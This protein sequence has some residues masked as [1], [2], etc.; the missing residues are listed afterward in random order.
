MRRNFRGKTGFVNLGIVIADGKGLDRAVR[1]LLHDR[2][3]Q[4]AVDSAGQKG[5][6]RHV[7]HHLPADGFGQKRFQRFLGFRIASGKR[8]CLPVKRGLCKGPVGRD[9]P[10]VEGLAKREDTP[11]RKLKDPLVNGGRRGDI[12]IH[13]ESS[14][15]I[16]VDLGRKAGDTQK[17]RQIGREGKERLAGFI[18]R[19][20]VIKGLFS[21]AVTGKP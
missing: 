7:G 12:F 20:A 9:V 21:G 1:E 10:G 15:R 4:R 5:P 8:T 14:Q 3:D 13:Q 18:L 2:H 16:P 11:G 17:Q 6:D 19:H